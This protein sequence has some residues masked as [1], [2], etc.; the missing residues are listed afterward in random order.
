MT[1]GVPEL[2]S[3]RANRRRLGSTLLALAIFGAGVGADRSGLLGGVPDQAD[4]GV[5]RQAW[6]L[7]HTNY[8]RSADLKWNEM[9]HAAIDA[10]TQAVGDTDHTVF[11]TPDEAALEEQ[12][13]AGSY[14]GIGVDLDESAAM[15]VVRSVTFDGPADQAGLQVGDRLVAID[16]A[17]TRA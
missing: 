13:L 10:M 4:F 11:L 17:S 9:A 12:D 7:L 15:P 2:G 14:I 5:I 1:D 3:R 16:G 8:V 6:D